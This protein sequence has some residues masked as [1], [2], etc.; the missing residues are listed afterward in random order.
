MVVK[1]RATRA[2]LPSSAGYPLWLRQY[3]LDQQGVDVDQ[4]NL[5][6]V[7]AKH[8]RFLIFQLV[9]RNLAPPAVKDE[10]VGAVPVLDHIQPL[11]DFAPQ[12][13]QAQIVADKDGP[14]DLAQFEEGLVERL[15]PGGASGSVV[16]K[17]SAVTYLMIS[18]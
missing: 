18:S 6:Q 3:L 14:I 1:Q 17:R 10:A 13:F 15:L 5:Q 11:V 8:R 16:P 7:Q 4:A 9:R 12:R 2:G